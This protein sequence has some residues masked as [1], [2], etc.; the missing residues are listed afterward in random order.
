MNGDPT[1]SA[2]IPWMVAVE[3]QRAAMRDA[4]GFPLIVIPE[5]ICI[6]KGNNNSK[7]PRKFLSPMTQ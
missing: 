4:P 7:W 5:R 1:V 6:E 3:E 2:S